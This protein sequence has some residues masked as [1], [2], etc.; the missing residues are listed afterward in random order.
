MSKFLQTYGLLLLILQTAVLPT[1]YVL[2][3]LGTIKKARMDILYGIRA[4][5][6]LSNDRGV[7]VCLE[8][9]FCSLAVQ[10]CKK[11]P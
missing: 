5:F 4:P 3:F 9:V 6:N 11:I 1:V 8:K 10:S 2:I 7:T